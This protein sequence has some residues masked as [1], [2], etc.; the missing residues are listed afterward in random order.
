MCGSSD[1]ST[2]MQHKDLARWSKCN[3]NGAKGLNHACHIDS[4]LEQED[5]DRFTIT[6]Y[7]YKPV[8]ETHLMSS[9][10]FSSKPQS[11][12]ETAT[13]GL[14]LCGV[15]HKLPVAM[16]IHK[17]QTSMKVIAVLKTQEI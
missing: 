2:V 9:S 11:N 3:A 7:T 10:Q 6:K 17:A 12:E 8:N 1:K 4:T 13:V 14:C 15:N 16:V 5:E